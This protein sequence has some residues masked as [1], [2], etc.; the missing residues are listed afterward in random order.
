MFRE[1]DGRFSLVQPLQPGETGRGPATSRNR[2]L[3]MARGRYVAFLDDDDQW[4][5]DEHLRFAVELLDETGA[6]LY[7]AELE[8]FRGDQR[9]HSSWIS[10]TE[11]GSRLL[12][13]ER[14]RT[15][16]SVYRVS[17]G[18]FLMAAA[19]KTPHPDT[20]V[21]RREAAQRSGGFLKRLDFGEDQVFVI[22][23]ADALEEV[24][25]CDKIVARY[26]L[27]EGN[28]VSLE[29]SEMERQLQ[30]VA[31][32]QYLRVNV[33]SDEA[34]RAAR[35]VEAWSLRE[36]G[37]LLQRRGDWRAAMTFFMQALAVYPT[38]GATLRLFQGAGATFRSA[39]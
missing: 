3:E 30:R 24:L 32:A 10:D 12:L 19:K 18:V 2:G 7:C 5:W 25:F 8:G 23:V 6:D 4:T 14:L 1:L 39:R 22:R 9:V 29:N 17:R 28:S 21:V 27:P 20:L 36:V 15:T 16:P 37:G 34:R 35:Q 38:L 11:P 13:G 26:R 31:A 33:R